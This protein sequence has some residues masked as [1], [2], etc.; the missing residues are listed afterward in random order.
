MIFQQQKENRVTLISNKKMMAMMMTRLPAEYP[1][2]GDASVRAQSHLARGGARLVREEDDDHD[3]H[4]GDYE[5]GDDHDANNDDANDYHNDDGYD[6][7][8]EES[9]NESM[10]T[11]IDHA[12]DI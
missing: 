8:G 12:D 5:Y 6:D 7:D 1:A 3:N 2:G 11:I 9:D 4:D 10:M